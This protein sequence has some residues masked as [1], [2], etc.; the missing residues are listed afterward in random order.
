M[1]GEVKC[2][3]QVFVHLYRKNLIFE[4]NS[5]ADFLITQIGTFLANLFQSSLCKSHSRRLLIFIE[6]KIG[7]FPQNPSISN[8]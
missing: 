5:S 2:D 7:H 3:Q 1:L 4:I 8:F 6:V